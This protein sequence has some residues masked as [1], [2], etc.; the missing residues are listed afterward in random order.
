VYVASYTI[1]QASRMIGRSVWTLRRW[2]HQGWVPPVRRHNG[3][4]RYSEA[5]VSAL[6]RFA[7]RGVGDEGEEEE[8]VRL[9]PVESVVR[10]WAEMEAGLIVESSV[11]R[12][13]HGQPV[14]SRAPDGVIGAPPPTDTVD[15]P[16]SCSICD[17]PLV[18]HGIHDPFGR[19]WLVAMCDRHHEQGRTRW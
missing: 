14:W 8:R 12:D 18:R 6:R 3:Q 16:G 17:R 5:D 19:R 2:E 15:L 4:R 1:S 9:E 7:V 10:P 13:A 11:A